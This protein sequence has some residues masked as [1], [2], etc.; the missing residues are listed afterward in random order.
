[1]LFRPSQSGIPAPRFPVELDVKF[2]RSYERDFSQGILKNI[3]LSGAFL[4]KDHVNVRA[5]DKILITLNVSGRKH[6][7]N[8]N[9][10][11]TCPQGCGLK[12]LPFNNKDTQIVDDLIYFLESKREKRKDILS[13]ILE[14]I[15]E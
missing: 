5:K 8:A 13:N 6:S 9:V 3:S 4:N 2:R 11:W 10:I 15:T 1:M 12:F 7:L 14:K